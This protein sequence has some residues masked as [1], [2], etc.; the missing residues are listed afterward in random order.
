MIRQVINSINLDYS[1]KDVCYGVVYPV[2]S[3]TG[4]V[5]G[6]QDGKFYQDAIPD[7]SR[8][9]IVYWED[10]GGSVV[11]STVHRQRIRQDV[12]LVVWMNFDKIATPYE[13]C[14]VDIMQAVPRRVGSSSIA[15]TGTLPKDVNLFNRYDY[16][17]GKQYISYP[18]DVIA[19]NYQIL[20]FRPKC[21]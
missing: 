17:E 12:R 13:D 1:F 3:K 16:R 7:S 4:R 10:Y 2:F 11:D 20:Y 8:K 9:S 6:S 14:I 18:Y 19:L 21:I 5:P 15:L